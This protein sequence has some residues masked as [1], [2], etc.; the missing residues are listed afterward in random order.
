MNDVLSPEEYA[1][2]M[3]LGGD[4][5]GLEDTIALQREQ[6]EQMRSKTPRGGMVGNR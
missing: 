6:A 5:Q 1:M 3:Q 2:L 4:N